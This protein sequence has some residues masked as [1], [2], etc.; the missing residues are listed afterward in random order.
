MATVSPL[1][2][3]WFAQYAEAEFATHLADLA[4]KPG[5]RFL[6]IGAYTGD[7]TV[8]MLDQILTGNDCYLVDVDTWQGSE[9]AAHVE[10]D[11]AAVERYYDDRTLEYRTAGRLVKNRCTSAEFFGGSSSFGRKCDFIYV[12]GDHTAPSV[13]ADAV[14][15]FQL[16]KPGGIIA[17]DD[18]QWHS[19]L[20]PLHDPGVA[21]DAFTSI[22]AEHLTLLAPP[23]LQVWT[24][25]NQPVTR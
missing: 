15:A 8:W 5:L 10:L 6:Q 19:G 23:G 14:N 1:F 7:A 24:R 25:R 16:L 20:G 17:F 22:F 21:I 4:G 11:F 12:D 13:L 9:E 3:N 2:P 18:Y